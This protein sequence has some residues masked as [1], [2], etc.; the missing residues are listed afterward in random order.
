MDVVGPHEEPPDPVLMRYRQDGFVVVRGVVDEAFVAHAGRH[1][2]WLLRR[3]PE[4]RGEALGHT[5]LPDDPCW[6]RLVS[7]R[8]LVDLA[9]RFL[10][11]DIALFASHYISKPP[12]DGRPVLWHQDA[13]YWPLDPM[14]VVTLWLAVDRSTPDNG[15]LRV[16]PG[17]HRGRLHDRRR[18][19]DVTSVFGDES[20]VDVDESAAVDIVLEPGDVEIHHPNLLHASGPN[21]SPQRRC[22]LTI[23]YI[24]TST[25]ILDPTAGSPFLLRGM[26][27]ANAYLPWPRHD[28]ARHFPLPPSGSGSGGGCNTSS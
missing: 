10:G 13:G 18:R 9:A 15:C 1:V 2:D 22:G 27:G 20:I 28:P 14:H 7:D 3:H 11:P 23:R 24:P 19:E 8:R 12:Y 25:R 21:D 26:P 6:L 5:M 4:V 17:S 16:L